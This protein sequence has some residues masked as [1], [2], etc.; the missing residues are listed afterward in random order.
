MS[1]KR[2]REVNLDAT[3]QSPKPRR[4]VTRRQTALDRERDSNSTS[5][6]EQEDRDSPEEKTEEQVEKEERRIRRHNAKIDA[7]EAKERYNQENA[8]QLKLRKDKQRNETTAQWREQQA[9]INQKLEETRARKEKATR[10]IESHKIAFEEYEEEQRE[11]RERRKARKEQEV[12][13]AAEAE[14]QG[15]DI[16]GPSPRIRQFS[17]EEEEEPRDKEDQMRYEIE[18]QRAQIQIAAE[19]AEYERLRIERE[20]EELE[21][22][23][24]QAEQERRA[25]AINEQALQERRQREAEELELA[26]KQAEQESRVRAINEQALQERRQREAEAAEYERQRAAEEAERRRAAE[27][28]DRERLANAQN[29]NMGTITVDKIADLIPLYSGEPTGLNA[30]IATVN[31]I[32]SL[33]ATRSADDQLWIALSI[34]AKLRGK[35]AEVNNEENLTAWP[36]IRNTLTQKVRPTMNL[37]C[38]ELELASARQNDKET[39][40]EFIERIKKLKDTVCLAFEPHPS[41]EQRQFVRNEVDRKA[42]TA[43]EVGLKN[44]TLKDL[45]LASNL[46]NFQ[47]TIN[48]VREKEMKLQLQNTMQAATVKICNFCSRPGHIERDCRTKNNGQ[49]NQNQPRR[50]GN[51]GA[52]FNCNQMG[53]IAAQCQNSPQGNQNRAQNQGYQNRNQNSGYQ[54]RGQNQGYQDRNNDGNNQG[55]QGGRNQNSGNQGNGNRP[56]NN[57]GYQGNRNNNANGNQQQQYNN[58]QNQSGGNQ[59]GQYNNGGANRGNGQGY[60]RGYNQNNRNEYNNNQNDPERQGRGQR[61]NQGGFNANPVTVEPEQEVVTASVITA[62]GNLN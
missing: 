15:R 5:V 17:I 32:W 14:L 4:I 30:Y 19:R 39:V 31:S 53:H 2:I 55:A 26:R 44:K 35:A 11:A 24:E 58:N 40:A 29:Y 33:V 43:I 48:F 52:C 7:E 38:A 47:E 41:E 54:N 61:N 59:Q 50:Q 25:R 60:N 46:A 49:N 12:R 9:V 56:Y 13:A 62:E 18:Q 23:K 42:I 36:Q 37:R 45:L 21:A 1:A 20:A 34:K 16:A 6:S 51:S 28:A 10:A 22:A 57:N 27:A 8:K 3:I